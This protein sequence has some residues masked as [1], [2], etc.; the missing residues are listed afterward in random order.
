MRPVAVVGVGQTRYAAKREDV[1]M[2][3]LVREAVLLRVDRGEVQVR[4]GPHAWRVAAPGTW[5][6]ARR[7]AWGWPG[8]RPA[9]TIRRSCWS[10]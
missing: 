1:S 8:M 6:W 7:C 4:A 5:S 2:P 9:A 3:E 10:H